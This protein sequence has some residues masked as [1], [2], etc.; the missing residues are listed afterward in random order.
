MKRLM[1]V[2]ALFVLA[3]CA[4]RIPDEVATIGFGGFRP[5]HP[6][7]GELIVVDAGHGGHDTGSM[8][9]AHA[10]VEKQ[11]ALDTARLLCGF[12]Q[13]L[14]YKTKMTR[15]NDL[16]VPLSKRAEIANAADADLFVSVHFNHCPSPE[17]HG[18]EIFTYKEKLPKSHRVI[19]STKLG[20]YVS[21]HIVKYTGV[22]SRGVKQGNLAVVRETK[23]PAI[24]VEAGFLSNPR[25]REKVKDP[26]HQK[27]IAWGIAKGVDHYLSMRAK[28][29]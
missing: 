28:W 27:A 2:L 23:M 15:S 5:V 20:E 7:R 6:Q 19:E 11:L 18:I 9:K 22:N 16:F 12:L 14:G 4:R 3:S 8:S 10:Y 21:N 17:P 1:I 29:Q 13:E 26:R 25:E 24:L